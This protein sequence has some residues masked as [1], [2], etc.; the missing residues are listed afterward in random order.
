[1]TA[2]ST[3][4]F[5]LAIPE[6]N[7]IRVDSSR[8]VLAAGYP[9]SLAVVASIERWAPRVLDSLGS[10]PGTIASAWTPAEIRR[11]RERLRRSP[12]GTVELT[13]PGVQPPEPATL[14]AALRR[15]MPR[16]GILV[17]DSGLHQEMVRRHFDVL[18]PRGLITP[19]DFQSMGF[20]V[21]AAIGAAI[22]AP[23]RKVVAVVGDGCFAM[24]GIEL[25][26]A[27]REGVSL[28]VIVIAD[29]YFNRIRMQ[30]VA[31]YGRGANVEL[32]NPD[33]FAFASA[34]G[35]RHARI[36]GNADQVLAEAIGFPGVSL[37][38]VDAGDAIG[39]HAVRARGLARDYVRGS[40]ARRAVSWWRKLLRRDR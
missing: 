24:S 34:V 15:A 2:A 11:L 31:E 38:E 22:A 20:G 32:L 19:S 14:F 27:V 13:V 26:T 10:D 25:L 35:A 40:S 5:S 12:R 28:T 30:Q 7:L 39:F 17:T 37:V 23:E 29:G 21:P 18:A 4:F 3:V 8:A 36:D 16:D 9:A 33:F 1:L 6:A